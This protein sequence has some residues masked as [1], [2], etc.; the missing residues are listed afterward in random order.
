[1]RDIGDAEAELEDALRAP[2]VDAVGRRS[3]L[4]WFVA[5]VALA[6]ASW[7]GLERLADSSSAVDW[8]LER[9][10]Y[11]SGLTTMPALSPDG[12]LVAY[13]SDR[14]GR[15]DLDIWVQQMGGGV[16]LRLTSDPADDHSPEFSPDGKQIVFRSE[17]AGGGVYL[18]S[19]LGGTERR[20]VAEGRRPRFSPGGSRLTYWTGQFRGVVS[21]R[22]SPPNSSPRAMPCGPPT[23]ALCSFWDA[24]TGSVR[25]RKRSIGGGLPWTGANRSRPIYSTRACS[26]RRSP[27]K[28]M[29]LP[30]PGRAKASCSRRAGP[31]GWFR[32]PWRTDVPRE[33]P[34]VSRV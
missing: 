12:Q 30:G 24:A 25:Y 9:I 6:A 13:A 2:A 5:G 15:G 21:R 26:S 8:S 19:A 28:G 1:M 16:P 27:F 33:S 3:A 17:R 29:A 7:L 14:G 18:A 22:D 32:Y 23:A 11:D 10:T 4:P 34:G 20:I 31:F